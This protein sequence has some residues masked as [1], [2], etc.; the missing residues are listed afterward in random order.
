MERKEDYLKRVSLCPMRVSELNNYDKF[1]EKIMLERDSGNTPEKYFRK[2]MVFYILETEYRID[3]MYDLAGILEKQVVMKGNRIPFLLNGAHISTVYP[4][5]QQD[6]NGD[7]ILCFGQRL[8]TYLP[9]TLIKKSCGRKLSD[10]LQESDYNPLWDDYLIEIYRANAYEL[11]K[12]HY[13]Y[14]F[15]NYEET[16]NFIREHND[17]LSYHQKKQDVENDKKE[18]LTPAQKTR[19]KIIQVINNS[20]F[21]EFEDWSRSGWK[22]SK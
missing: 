15:G 6:E 12:H 17:I 16:S 22:A 18:K 2:F 20:L 4:N 5:L 8:N 14:C 9:I 21:S 1:V 10:L 13:V 19:L 11:F 7:T 3:F